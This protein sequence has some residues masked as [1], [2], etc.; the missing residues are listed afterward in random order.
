[1]LGAGIPVSTPSSDGAPNPFQILPNR[2]WPIQDRPNPP[3]EKALLPLDRLVGNEPFQELPPTPRALF[4]FGPSVHGEKRSGYG[5]RVRVAMFALSS[6]A[7]PYVDPMSHR[8]SIA[9][10]SALPKHLFGKPEVA[11]REAAHLDRSRGC[12]DAPRFDTIDNRARTMAS[13]RLPWKET[14]AP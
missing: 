9:R 10:S 11:R 14:A 2:A 8:K 7:V 5:Q 4:S 1:M 3:K 12:R 13:T 6:F